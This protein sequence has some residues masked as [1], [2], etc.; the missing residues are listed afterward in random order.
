[1]ACLWACLCLICAFIGLVITSLFHNPSPCAACSGDQFEVVDVAS[2]ANV[3][4]EVA[5]VVSKAVVSEKRVVIEKIFPKRQIADVVSYI[6][7]ADYAYLHVSNTVLPRMKLQVTQGDFTS[8]T[9]ASIDDDHPLVTFI[10][11]T[12]D[13]MRAQNMYHGDGE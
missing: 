11:L 10:K 9:K 3:A 5:D 13:N 2:E 1:M 4:S 7:T 6:T 8:T 12:K